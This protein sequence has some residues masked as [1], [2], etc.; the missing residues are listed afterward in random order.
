MC[1]FVFSLCCMQR[2]ETTLCLDSSQPNNVT[3]HVP[4]TLPVEKLK[5]A[6]CHSRRRFLVD[7]QVSTSCVLLR[8]PFCPMLCNIVAVF[9]GVAI[10]GIACFVSSRSLHIATSTAVL[11][12]HVLFA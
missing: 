11:E 9:A 5:H 4:P 8:L 10:Y 6:A 7:V 3:I 1:Q 12:R 2:R